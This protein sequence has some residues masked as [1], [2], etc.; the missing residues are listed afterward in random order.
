MARLRSK[1]SALKILSCKFGGMGKHTPLSP[2]GAEDMCNFRILPGGVLKTRMGY[3]LHKYFP[4]MQKV[5]GVWQGTLKGVSLSLFVVD[6]SIYRLMQNATSESPAGELS[7]SEGLVHFCVYLDDLYLLDGKS[8]YQYSVSQN[9]F[10]E[11]EAYVPLFGYQWSPTSYGDV[12]EEINM[13]TPRLRVHYYNSTASTVFRLPYYADTVDIV[14][15]DGQVITDYT[16]TPKTDRITV[17]TASPPTILEVGFTVDLNEEIRQKILAAQLSLIYSHNGENKLLLWGNDARVFC[18]RNVTDYMLSSSHVLYPKASPLYFCAED[19]LF[20]GDSAHPVTAMCPLY[21]TVLA[22]TDDRIWNLTFEKGT[23]QATLAASN[24]GCASPFGAI[25]YKNSVIAVIGNDVYRI[26]ASVARPEQISFDRLSIGLEDRITSDFS[27]R[28]HLFWNVADGE[29][30]MRDPENE[31]GDVLVWNTESDEW[32]RFDNI[33]ASF[34]FKTSDGFG[35]AQ[36]NG[37]LLF[38]RSLGTDFDMPI[39][40]FYKSAYMDFGTPEVPRRS[41]RAYLYF[42]AS[43][44][45]GT[46]LFETERNGKLFNLAQP[47]SNADT[48]LQTMRFGSHRY[49]FLRFTISANASTPAEFYRLDIHSLP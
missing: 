46:V 13:L 11:M 8:I 35:F 22:F 45:D 17:N 21:D 49:R 25:P 39:T 37:S 19:V 10:L 36:N 3:R 27:K 29:I 30:W 2:E 5:R 47:L 6:S 7:T 26:S 41:T 38:D 48:Y 31:G 34:F 44:G 32:Y 4:G 43:E 9:K 20:L 24:I 18:S 15:A 14:R 1:H 42:L 33:P 12:N 23:V 28:V 16:F 40:A